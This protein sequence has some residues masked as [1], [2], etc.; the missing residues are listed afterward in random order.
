[1]R[2]PSQQHCLLLS[3]V[4][5]HAYRRGRGGEGRLALPYLTWLLQAGSAAQSRDDISA[6]RLPAAGRRGARCCRARQSGAAT[7]AT[8]PESSSR[9]PTTSRY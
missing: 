7:P 2:P 9:Q 8:C 4:S 5:F 6:G 3:A 1:M